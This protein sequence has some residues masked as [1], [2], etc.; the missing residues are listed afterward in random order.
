MKVAYPFTTLILLLMFQTVAAQQDL[1]A[2]KQQLNSTSN[3]TIIVQTVDRLNN[4]LARNKPRDFL[5]ILRTLR[6]RSDLK[7]NKLVQEEVL[8]QYGICYTNLRKYD[9]AVWYFRRALDLNQATNNIL[10]RG[11]IHHDLGYAYYE[12]NVYDSTMLYYYKALEEKKQAGNSL[13]AAVTLNGLGLVQRMRNN[14]ASSREYYTEALSIYEKASDRRMLS[15][16][17]NIATLYNLQKRYDSATAVF[18]RVYQLAEGYK[19][20]NLMFSAKVN[21]ALGLN[22][23]YKY[24]EALPVFQE[25]S[26]DPRVKQIEDLNNAVLY[27]LGQA[28]YGT[29]DYAKAIPILQQCLT[30]RFKNTKFQ[31][32]AAITNLLYMAEKEQG[33]Y[34]QALLYYEQLKGYSDSLMNN[35]RTAMLE[36]LDAKYKATQKEQQIALLNKENQ[37]KE[38]DLQRQRNEVL[39]LAAKAQQREQELI[40]LNKDNELKDL[41]IKEQQKT[42]LLSQ[43]QNKQST[44]ELL[45]LK[46]QAKLKDLEIRD[47][48]KQK[49][50]Y[51]L[52]IALTTLLAGGAFYLY[53][54]K[55]KTTEQ[56][57]E[58]NAIISK[59]LNEKETLLK[60]IHHRVKNNLQVISSLLKLQSKSISDNV[61]L[62]ALKEGSNRVRSMALIHQNLYTDE[63]LVSVDVKD[64]I[65]KLSESLFHSY[66]IEPGK[67]Q[68][69]TQV[70][71]IKLDVDTIIP[72]GLILNELITNALKYAFTE[73]TEQGKIGVTLKENTR[74]LLLEVQDNGK[75][76]PAGFQPETAS[77][78]GFQLIRSFAAKLKAELNIVNEQGTTVQM[79]IAKA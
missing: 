53:S 37:L 14:I 35:S 64:Y 3:E 6:E 49:L 56:L 50:L 47:N 38:I 18:N 66:N 16:M 2:L 74:G 78:M 61:A 65:E 52:G 39:L 34:E 28:Y 57:A 40:L 58:K 45:L 31:T 33:H 43:A 55:Q 62:E 17:M 5:D 20:P 25:L 48:K 69:T 77:S 22:Y 36:E 76:L 79:L 19:D 11:I 27:G 71:P 75:G 26:K 44:Q 41:S 23:Q 46:Q 54:N 60:E 29:K 68:L 30:L 51:T 73:G 1:N 59:A 24:A 42:L 13:S 12:Q 7:A 10:Q 15:V 67:I 9:S 63:N 32:L 8:H 21:I 4:I 70:D 72:L